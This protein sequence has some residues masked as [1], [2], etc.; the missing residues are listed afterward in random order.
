MK[1][2]QMSFATGRLKYL[3]LFKNLA[4]LKQKLKIKLKLKISFSIINK[5]GGRN[6][7]KI[8]F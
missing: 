2:K 6:E 8:N 4:H 3:H 7:N 1:I 5:K